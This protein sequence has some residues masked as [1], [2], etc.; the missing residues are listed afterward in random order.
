V[1]V[2]Q[3][4]RLPGLEAKVVG[5]ARIGPAC[6]AKAAGVVKVAAQFGAQ[7]RFVERGFRPGTHGR[8]IGMRWRT[9]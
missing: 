8:M 6:L 7:R 1:G 2:R 9:L 5:C 4:L 3:A